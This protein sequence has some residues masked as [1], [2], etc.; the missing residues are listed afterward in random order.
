MVRNARVDIYTIYLRYISIKLNSPSFTKS[1]GICRESQWCEEEK[2]PA[3]RRNYKTFTLKVIYQSSAFREKKE[4]TER[5]AVMNDRIILLNF[6]V[7]MSFVSLLIRFHLVS[8][9]GLQTRM[10]KF[11]E[12]VTI[13]QRCKGTR[14]SSFADFYLMKLEIPVG[15]AVWMQDVVLYIPDNII[16]Y[17][18]PEI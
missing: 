12:L 5:T 10:K 1:K 15:S 8:N 4:W 9:K 11:I 17:I 2:L 3:K 16:W 14:S 13:L 7:S 6:I 18:Q